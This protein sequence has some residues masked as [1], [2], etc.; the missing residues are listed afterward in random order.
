MISSRKMKKLML[1][2]A[3]PVSGFL[4]EIHPWG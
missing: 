4:L 2:F 1:A 3:V